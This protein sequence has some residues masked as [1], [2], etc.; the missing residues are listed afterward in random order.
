MRKK[1]DQIQVALDAHVTAQIVAATPAFGNVG[2]DM[3]TKIRTAIGEMRTLGANQGIS[4]SF[5]ANQRARIPGTPSVKKA[6]K[7]G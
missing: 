1:N 5:R 2:A 7:G 6:M 3:I 4:I